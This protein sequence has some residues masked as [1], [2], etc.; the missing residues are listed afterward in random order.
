M[1]LDLIILGQEREEIG[2]SVLILQNQYFSFPNSLFLTSLVFLMNEL[3][4]I[5]AQDVKIFGYSKG[6]VI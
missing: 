2:F 5:S 1:V 6:S 3:G 4:P